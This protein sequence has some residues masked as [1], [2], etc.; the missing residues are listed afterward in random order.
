[1]M[2]A[3][4]VVAGDLVVFEGAG[5]VGCEDVFDRAAAAADDLDAVGIEHVEGAVSHV[6][7]EHHAHADARHLW[8]DVGF[9]AAAFWRWHI[10]GGDDFSAFHGDDGVVVAVTEMVVDA[11]VS[12]W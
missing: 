2:V 9:A 12:G 1:M 11:S 4:V 7:G 8:R 3:V 6:A 10:F 5:E